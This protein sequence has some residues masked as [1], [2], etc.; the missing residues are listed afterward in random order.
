M[1]H[2]IEKINKDLEMITK[3]QRANS[4]VEKYKGN[5]KFT[6]GTQQQI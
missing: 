4:A 1:I 5:K 3:N 6:G 2:Q